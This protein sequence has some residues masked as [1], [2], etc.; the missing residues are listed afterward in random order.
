[1]NI[2]LIHIR[3]SKV[4]CLLNTARHLAHF[5]NNKIVFNATNDYQND[6]FEIADMLF[7]IFAI[8]LEALLRLIIFFLADL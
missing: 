8:V 4:D 1:M 3:N 2:I 7:C 6:Y 5:K